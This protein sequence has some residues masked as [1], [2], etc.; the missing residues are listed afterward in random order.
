MKIAICD[1]SPESLEIIKSYTI[2]CM[3]Q[4][5]ID[6]ELYTF[7]NSESLIAS[8]LVFDIAMLDIEMPGV[9][10]LICAKHIEK[11][12]ENA[13]IIMI[14][15][16]NEYLDD[17]ME[18]NVYRYLSKPLDK[19]RFQNNL[20]A[21]VNRYFKIN[22]PVVFNND[23]GTIKIYTVDILYLYIDNRNM[24]IHTVDT[25]YKTRRGMAW[26]KAALNPELFAQVH[27][28]YLVNLRYVTNFDKTTV[29]LKSR[30]Q[31]CKVYCSR[32]Y[33]PSFKKAFY[34][35]ING[36]NVLG[37]VAYDYTYLL[38]LIL[39]CRSHNRLHIF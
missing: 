21:A 9:N 4:Q 28:S 37:G 35:Y 24:T 36:T 27:K 16:Y 31:V 7:T 20:T 23:D 5:N 11:Q 17:A 14:T 15:T 2:E 38:C 10:G 18:L 3:V 39:Y 33:F 12:N 30:G 6:Y 25:E 13:V 8:G 32:K 19:K 26:W 1:D 22:Q 29:T 34:D